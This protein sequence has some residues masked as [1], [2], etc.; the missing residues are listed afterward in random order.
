MHNALEAQSEPAF[1]RFPSL[2]SLGAENQARTPI[3]MHLRPGGLKHVTSI[4]ANSKKAEQ[5]ASEGKTLAPRTTPSWCQY[6]PPKLKGG[7]RLMYDQKD[8][9]GLF[10]SLPLL[11][12]LLPFPLERILPAGALK[13]KGEMSLQQ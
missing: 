2:E 3:K 11:R 6:P 13:L 5:E 9:D 12:Q 8:A 1:L 4:K 7:G 10:T